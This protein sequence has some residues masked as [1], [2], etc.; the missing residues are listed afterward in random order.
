MSAD[1]RPLWWQVYGDGKDDTLGIVDTL[2]HL[3]RRID[4]IGD[5]M[6]S[7]DV[8]SMAQG[9]VAGLGEVLMDYAQQID[10]LSKHIHKRYSA[11]PSAKAER[12]KGAAH[13]REVTKGEE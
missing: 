11:R 5:V 9:S 3:R 13:L 8:S 6:S 4:A 2:S 10:A 1:F 7:A 12:A